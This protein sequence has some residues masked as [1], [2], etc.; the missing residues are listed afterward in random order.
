MQPATS[1]LRRRALATAALFLGLAAAQAQGLPPPAPQNVLQL[2]A[3]GSVEVRQ[4]LLSMALGTTREGEDPAAVQRELTAAV[5]AALAQAK[6]L[7]QPGALDVRTGRFG[8]APRWR[9]GRVD[10]W[11]GSADIL[12]EGHDFARIAQA[13]T[14]V[15]TLS[16]RGVSFGLSNTARERAEHDAQAQAV[17]RFRA[18][19]DELARSFG[20]AGYTLREVAVSANEP[21]Y[22]TMRMAAP[23][24]PGV[25]AAAPVPVEAG[26]TEVR[27]TV[28]GSVQLR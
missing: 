12:I 14:R 22:A 23:M 9:D 10:G 8:L 27:I 2:A 25:A 7:V 28:S 21:G 3:T 24:A 18:K 5:D 4:D 1:L 11:T 17:Q 6:P 15:T 13:A 26:K 19:A 20:F 16:V